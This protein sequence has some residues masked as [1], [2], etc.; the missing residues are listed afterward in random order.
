MQTASAGVEAPDE[1]A[2]GLGGGEVAALQ[3]KLKGQNTARHP[4]AAAV[5]VIQDRCFFWDSAFL[6]FFG[7]GSLFVPIIFSRTSHEVQKEFGLAARSFD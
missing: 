3:G 2:G 5:L 4:T 6:R 1:V 7:M